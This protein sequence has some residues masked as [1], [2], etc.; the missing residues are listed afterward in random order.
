MR[1]LFNLVKGNVTY[2]EWTLSLCLFRCTA[3]FFCAPQGIYPPKNAAH[4]TPVERSCC[5]TVSNRSR[6]GA[7]RLERHFR[8]INCPYN[9]F[10]LAKA[11]SIMV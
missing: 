7:P 10:F 9:L 1:T 4:Q 6:T 5:S 2:I 3:R 11:C 8:S